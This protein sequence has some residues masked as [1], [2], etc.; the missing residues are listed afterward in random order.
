[1][2][3][4]ILYYFSNQHTAP[5]GTKTTYHCTVGYIGVRPLTKISKLSALTVVLHDPQWSL[6]DAMPT[7]TPEQH[8]GWTAGHKE[9][10]QEAG[11]LLR[12]THVPAQQAGSIPSHYAPNCQK[13]QRIKGMQGACSRSLLAC[14]MAPRHQ[15]PTVHLS[16]SGGRLIMLRCC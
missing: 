8:P 5:S 3:L 4:S 2:I 1:M 7:H 15:N 9:F 11:L 6:S 13:I 14:Y 10:R 12:L 16:L